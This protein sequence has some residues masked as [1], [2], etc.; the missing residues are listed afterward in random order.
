VTE[1]E[2]KPLKYPVMF[3]KADLVVL[4]KVD[5]L[6]H[7]PGFDLA[8]LE[9]ALAQVMPEPRSI[10]TS[11]ATGEGLDEWLEW[12]A[13]EAHAA[14]TRETPVGDPRVG[15]PAYPNGGGGAG[16]ARGE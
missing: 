13:D 11:A 14:R 3:R 16:A 10:R 2:D 4:T 15:R 1:G 8:A 5:L 6:P 9:S 12:L 7:L